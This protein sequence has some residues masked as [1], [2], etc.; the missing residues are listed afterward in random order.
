MDIASEKA[1]E[2]PHM[3]TTHAEPLA[4]GTANTPSSFAALAGEW[5]LLFARCAGRPF[6]PSCVA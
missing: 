5:D 2:A 1:A 3:S 4:L 6:L